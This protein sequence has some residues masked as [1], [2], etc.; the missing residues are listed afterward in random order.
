MNEMLVKLLHSIGIEVAAPGAGTSGGGRCSFTNAVLGLKQGGL[1]AKVKPEWFIN[2]GSRFLRPT[3]D[4]I[5]PKA[6]MSVGE[7]AYRAIM[8]AYRLPRVAFRNAV[9]RPNGFLPVAGITH[10]G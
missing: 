10:L 1:Q 5:A 8:T 7:W 2:C 6:V 4:L 3:I 9:E